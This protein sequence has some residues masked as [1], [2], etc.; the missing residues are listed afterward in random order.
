MPFTTELKA[1]R[2]FSREAAEWCAEFSQAKS[3]SCTTPISAAFI[4]TW[5]DWSISTSKFAAISQSPLK[6]WNGKT[7]FG[8]VLS[9]FIR[10]I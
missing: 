7:I 5:R 3:T 8:G 6:G 1:V 9:Y 10:L 4:R 2:A